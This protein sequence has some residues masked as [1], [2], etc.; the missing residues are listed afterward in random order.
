MKNDC[1]TYPFAINEDG[2]PINIEEITKEKRHEH[3]YHCYGCGAELIPVLGECRKHHFRHD[4]GK[5]CNPDKYLHEYAKAAIKKKFDESEHFVVK[6]HAHQKC[7]KADECNFYSRYHWPECEYD[8][9]YAIDLKRFYD[10]CETEKEYYYNSTNSEKRFVA[11]LILTHSQK[12]DR[13]PVYIEIWVT[14]ECTDEKKQ[15]GGKIIEIKISEE[16]DVLREIIESD[17]EN[18][19][20]RFFN[21]EKNNVPGTKRRGL[22]LIKYLRGKIVQKNIDCS[23]LIHFNQNTENEIITDS[24]DISNDFL[25]LF[26]AAILNNQGINI[27]DCRLCVNCIV[28]KKSGEHLSCQLRSP[29]NCNSFKYNLKEGE[30]VLFCGGYIPLWEQ[31]IKEE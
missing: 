27:P 14:H 2:K 4:P 6:Y 9:L 18:L 16:S 11:D 26:Y 22:M 8:G 19:P 25:R 21:F 28:N 13:E 5:T 31:N 1:F 30:K 3:H 29:N 7:R 24:T 10:T 15:N 12:K 20:I 23:K 17:D